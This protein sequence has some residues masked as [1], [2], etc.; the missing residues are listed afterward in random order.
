MSAKPNKK[1]NNVVVKHVPE[2][3]K[4]SIA[5]IAENTGETISSLIRPKLRE[6][7]NSYSENM[8]KKNKGFKED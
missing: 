1:N 5:N 7:V 3:I 4:E 8:R 6:L 2:D